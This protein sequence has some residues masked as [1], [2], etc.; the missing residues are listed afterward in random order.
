MEG[1]R[2]LEW[3]GFYAVS[4]LRHSESLDTQRTIG[5]TDLSL[6]LPGLQSVEQALDTSSG[7]STSKARLALTR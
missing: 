2:R 1:N 7:R 4:F 3:L 6:L 5:N